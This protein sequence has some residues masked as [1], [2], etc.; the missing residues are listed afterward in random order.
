M[1]NKKYPNNLRHFR[2]KRRLTQRE[3]ALGIGHAT[4]GRLSSWESG[5]AAPSIE[6]MVRLSIL[7]KVSIDRLYAPLSRRMHRPDKKPETVL[8]ESKEPGADYS[9]MNDERLVDALAEMIVLSYLGQE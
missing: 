5:S 6:N 4:A 9:S 1:P 2:L 8:S 7:Y 3:A